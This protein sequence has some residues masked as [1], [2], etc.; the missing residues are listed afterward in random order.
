MNVRRFVTISRVKEKAMRTRAKN[1]GHNQMVLF[2]GGRSNGCLNVCRSHDKGECSFS[3]HKKRA[4]S[5]LSMALIRV[6]FWKPGNFCSPSS[7]SVSPVAPEGITHFVL[8][9]FR[10]QNTSGRNGPLSVVTISTELRSFY[11]TV[12]I[13]PFGLLDE[14]PAS[15][16]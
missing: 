8:E 5:M 9:P 10:T 3:K 6:S 13:L 2:A 14:T 7:N 15:D 16:M 12:S 1:R 11:S 4:F